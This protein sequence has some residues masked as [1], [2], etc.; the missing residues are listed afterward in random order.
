MLLSRVVSTLL[1]DTLQYSALLEG[2]NGT[3]QKA[4]GNEDYVEDHR[5]SRD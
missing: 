4:L 3:F 1:G 5:T 2:S